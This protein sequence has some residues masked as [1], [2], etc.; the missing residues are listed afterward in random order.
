MDRITGIAQGLA[1]DWWDRASYRTLS[2]NEAPADMAEAYAIQR[3]LR[4]LLA[5]R[6][7]SVAGRKIALSSQAMQQMVGIGSP[8]AG[9]FFAGD[10]LRSPAKVDLSTFRH[11]GLEAE[12]AFRLKRDVAPGQPLDDLPALI[13]EVCPAFELIEDKGADYAALDVLTLVADNAWCGA[14]VLGAPIADWQELDLSDLGGV[15]GQTGQADEI[16]NTGAADPWGSLGWLLAHVTGQ[17]ETLCA[18]EF[19]ITGSVVRTRFPARGQTLRYQI[20]GQ[21]AV[22]LSLV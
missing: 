13:A 21:D 16:T 2:G 19:L 12:L 6:R 20:T 22:E 7:G 10:L 5:A 18:G 11:L 4:P 15:L 17:G 9:N 8:I 1:A 3:A 14:V